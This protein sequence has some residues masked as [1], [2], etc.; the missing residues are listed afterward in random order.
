MIELKSRNLLITQENM[1]GKSVAELATAYKTSVT[2]IRRI[3][4]DTKNK[5]PEEITNSSK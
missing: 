2:N 3:I 5:Y 4:V 1:K